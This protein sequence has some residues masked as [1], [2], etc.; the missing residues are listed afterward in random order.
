MLRITTA[1]YDQIRR[2]AEDAYPLECCGILIGNFD[3]DG[4]TVRS[5]ACCTN[6][7]PGSQQTTYDI[8]PR[9]LIRAQRNARERGM[10]IVGFYHSHPDHPPSP[11]PT[12][13]EHAHWIGCSYVIT[14]VSPNSAADTKSFLLAG[15][16][17]EDK[18][19]V[20]EDIVVNPK[21]STTL[22]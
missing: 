7:A 19:F 18:H 22:P 10:E 16:L 17:E 8:D 4:R 6:A 9:E 11:S 5:V 3:A 1:D 15:R 2:H 14:S 21:N 12:D 20:E 13:L